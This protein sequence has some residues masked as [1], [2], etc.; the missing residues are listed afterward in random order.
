MNW[1]KIVHQ[2]LVE[3]EERVERDELIVD[4]LILRVKALEDQLREP[5]NYNK[6]SKDHNTGYIGGRG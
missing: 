1:D 4:D 6:M 3:L 5:I 2:R